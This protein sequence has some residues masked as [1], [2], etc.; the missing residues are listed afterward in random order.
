MLYTVEALSHA[1]QILEGSGHRGYCSCER[2]QRLFQPLLPPPATVLRHP[3]GCSELTLQR[4][5]LAAQSLCLRL[6]PLPCLQVQS[7]QGS[8]WKA[9][10]YCR[11]KDLQAITPPANC[12]NLGANLA[13]IE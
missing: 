6:C 8:A 4:R 5:P 7:R 1:L 12:A 9:T 2:L 3:R 13:V 11:E 10:T